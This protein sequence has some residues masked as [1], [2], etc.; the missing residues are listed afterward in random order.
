MPYQAIFSRDEFRSILGRVVK[1]C[2]IELLRQGKLGKRGLSVDAKAL[3]AC[4]RE[5]IR[6]IK[7]EKIRELIGA[8]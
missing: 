2:R 3:H 8:L 7:Q 4:V 5:K 1:E 6:K